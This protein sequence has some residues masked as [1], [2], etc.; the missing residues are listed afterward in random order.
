[1][2]ANELG[3]DP[4]PR[5]NRSDVALLIAGLAFFAIVFIAHHASDKG[6]AAPRP[7]CQQQASQILPQSQPVLIGCGGQN[8]AAQPGAPGSP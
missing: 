6:G 2:N 5:I 3:R 4:N 7:A 1:M 8:P